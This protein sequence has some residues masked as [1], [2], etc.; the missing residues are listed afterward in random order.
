[1]RQNPHVRICGGPASATTLVYPTLKWGG[2]AAHNVRYLHRRQPV[3]V[4]ELQ[5][6]HDLLSS[7]RTSPKRDL[8]REP[9]NG[10]SAHGRKTVLRCNLRLHRRHV[11]D[12]G[13]ELNIGLGF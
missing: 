5:H 1:M 8:C 2:V 6:L 10:R 7:N 4:R 12:G 3:L 11:L 9:D 13:V